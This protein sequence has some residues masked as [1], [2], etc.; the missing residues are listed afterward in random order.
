MATQRLSRLHKHILQWLAA[1]HQQTKG[2]IL[3]SHA[4]LVQAL[5]RDKGTISRSLRL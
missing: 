5:Q 4:E 1:D 3:S 2:F